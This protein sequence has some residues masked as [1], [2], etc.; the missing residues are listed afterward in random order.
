ME[1]VGKQPPESVKFTQV[2]RFR[3]AVSAVVLRPRAQRGF[4]S[5]WRVECDTLVPQPVRAQQ[6]LTL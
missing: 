2:P 1:E 6:M 5:A 3:A 4:Q